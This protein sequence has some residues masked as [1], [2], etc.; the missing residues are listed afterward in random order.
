MT[1]FSVL[2]SIFIGPLKLIF[3]IIFEFANRFV[4][5]PGFSIIFLSLVMNILVLPLYKRADA[6]QEAARDIDL[7]L[8]K[9]V[10]HIKKTF[11]GDERMMILQTYYRQNNYKPTSALNGSVSLLL[12]IPFFMAAYQ[13]LSH[14]EILKGVSLGP[15]KDL[16]APDGLIV[17]G[18][19]SINL[20]PVLMTLVNV[21]SSALYLKGFPLK[22]KIQLYAMAGFFLVFLYTSPSGLVFYWTLN[23]VFSL[24]KTIF[25]KIKNP[26]KVLRILTCIVGVLFLGLG[27][28]YNTDSVKKRL[29]LFAIGLLLQL[30]ILLPVLKG[31]IKFTKKVT[32]TPNKKLFVLGSLLLTVLV[33]L[34]IPSTYIAASPQEYVDISYFHHPLLYI[35][36]SLALSVG[37]FMVWLRV[38]YWLAND[39]GKVIFDKL[40]WLLSGVMLINYM[41]FGTKLGNLSAI[42]MYDNGMDF[43]LTEQL[44]NVG[45]ILA[46]C[47]V[48]YFCVVKWKRVVATV[49]VTCIIALTGMSA[50][51]VVTI[52][53]SVDRVVGEETKNGD[54][55]TFQL[56]QTGKNVIVLMLDR[57]LGSHVP[58]LFN[59]KPELKEKF[60]GF[61]FYN[62]TI[63]FGGKTNFGVSAM[64]GGYEYTPVEMNK[65]NTESL[66]SKHNEALKVMPSIFSKNGYDVTVCDPV[67]ANYQIIPDLT[68]FNDMPEVDTYI[69]RGKFSD[70]KNKQ[71]VIDNNYRNFFCF[72]LMK[73]MPVLL[74]PTIYNSGRY[75][76]VVSEKES[77][78]SSSQKIETLST[79]TGTNPNF[80]DC[81][82]VLTNLPG[83][84]KITKEQTNT[85]MFMSND[86]THEPMLLK[87]PEYEPANVVDNTKYDAEH[88]DRFTMGDKK[89]N[90]ETSYQFVHYQTNMAA[91]IQLGNWFDYMRE[92]KVYDNT[93]IILVA[94]HGQNLA[95]L[96]ELI[97]ED[98]TGAK[99]DGSNYFPL[100][101]VKDFNSKEFTVS[102]QF[103]T[104]ADVPTLATA[105]I[106]DN[107]TNPFTGKAINSSEKTAHDQYIIHSDL[108]KI[109]ENNGN[110]FKPAQWI[111]VKDNIWN[112]ENW[113]YYDQ[114]VVLDQHKAP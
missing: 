28:I 72:S 57:A 14:L 70:V 20:L 81:Y 86:V 51:N 31:K 6:M 100:L 38:F 89:L 93:R 111:S 77:A 97:I 23:N 25:Y 58:F 26:Q 2:E 48:L 40:V 65:R 21:I 73:T 60:A 13:F 101:M 107:P 79:S 37:T 10:A 12:E 46:V 34:L 114:T 44:L 29:F 43:S 98:E 64:L 11:S 68:I 67:Y 15:I 80:M 112:K 88:I 75:N 5:H 94:D 3:E 108:W 76:Q 105:D 1:F 24:V 55:P 74:Q 69:S 84:T 90:I 47:A 92:N 42:L 41:F 30:P 71:S 91:F 103:M 85:F 109:N 102:Q 82:N 45:I 63:S 27:F 99:I 36:N 66:V 54:V 50:V 110:T 9:G 39:N 22:T 52:K 7:K 95:Q 33:G 59:E 104:N 19:L 17:I 32:A 78:S 4:N 106:I 87:E 16:S 8:Q 113:E 35:V 53:N 83:I 61:T 96:D 56:S 49:L 62:N 18:A